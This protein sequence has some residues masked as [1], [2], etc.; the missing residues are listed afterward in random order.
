ME[1]R[2][3]DEVSGNTTAPAKKRGRP[4]TKIRTAIANS[5]ELKDPGDSTFPVNSFSLTVNKNDGDICLS[6]LDIVISWIKTH[7]IS[8]GVSTEVGKRAHNLHLQG[9]LEMRYPITKPYQT[10]LSSILKKLL[11]P[12]GGYRVLVKPL[13]TGQT[14][15]AMIGYITKD[16]GEPHYQIRTHNI[17]AQQLTNGRRDHECLLTSFDD[18]K[19][20]LNMKNMFN[21]CFRFSQ[22]CLSPAIVLIQY[23]L[24]YMIQ[25]G[26]YIFSPDF[27]S[28]FK[29]IDIS[30]ADVL[31]DMV[32][33]PR[34]VTIGMILKL[35]FDSR[36][37]GM[38]VKK[39]LYICSS[40]FTY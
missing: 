33:E 7:C 14:I 40:P 10:R 2:K 20:I 19:K 11:P 30:E 17:T 38:K 6:I 18:N 22:R 25:S 21:E 35:V 15:P 8:G 36:S 23:V 26:N 9:V 4:F 3:Q 1:K 29:K 37:Y 28:T 13:S 39:L 12:G 34:K 16:Q 31:W 27:I 32:Y 5:L 24:L